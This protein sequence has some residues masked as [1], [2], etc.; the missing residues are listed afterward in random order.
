MSGFFGARDHFPEQMRSLYKKGFKRWDT[1][2]QLNDPNFS[3]CMNLR[4]KRL[5]LA[6]KFFAKRGFSPL[7]PMSL[8][9]QSKRERWPFI[10]FGPIWGWFNKRSRSYCH[11]EKYYRKLAKYKLDKLFSIE[12]EM[13]ENRLKQNVNL[14]YLI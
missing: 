2:E 14:P 12:E 13:K 10:P 7:F 3:M 9:R 6:M 5:S 8:R 4:L 1:P 11:S